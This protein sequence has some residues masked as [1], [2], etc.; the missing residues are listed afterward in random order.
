MAGGDAALIKS[1]EDFEDHPQ[2][3]EQQLVELGF[4]ANDLLIGST[5]GGQTSWVIGAIWKSTTITQRKPYILYG[6][7]DEILVQNV[8]RSKEFIHSPKINKI[9]CNVGYMALAG[10]T[11]MQSTTILMH[12]IGI[13]LLGCDRLRSLSNPGKSWT[14]YATSNVDT[15]INYLTQTDFSVVQKW[16]EFQSDLYKRKQ[17]IT[18][19]TIPYYGISI[20]TDTT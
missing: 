7:T 4:K 12:A 14:E 19:H 18:Y 5:E 10:S 15:F 16:I 1:V 17:Q 9:N 6:N 20:L 3:A 2:F 11:R 8:E 13:A